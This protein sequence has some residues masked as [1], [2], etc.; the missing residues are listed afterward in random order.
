MCESQLYKSD[1]I[2]FIDQQIEV[3]NQSIILTE[4]IAQSN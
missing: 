3:R 2:N 1:D 4:I